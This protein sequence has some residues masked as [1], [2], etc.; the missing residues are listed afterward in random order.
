MENDGA[1]CELHVIV[2]RNEETKGT[3]LIVGEFNNIHVRVSKELG[4]YMNSSLNFDGIVMNRTNL[5][6][7]LK[8]ILCW[9]EEER[10]SKDKGCI[11]H[12]VYTHYPNTVF[13]WA[14]TKISDIPEIS[15]LFKEFYMKQITEE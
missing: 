11:Y 8:H 2:K 15:T 1:L 6:I 7:L 12:S 10:Y 3:I 9:F 13:H 4:V 14:L 5:L